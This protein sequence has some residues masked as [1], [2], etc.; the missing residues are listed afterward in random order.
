ML[1]KLHHAAARLPW[2]QLGGTQLV[3]RQPQ[4]RTA[5]TA[6]RPQRRYLELHTALHWGPRRPLDH[7]N[8]S[9]ERLLVA[10]MRVTMAED[11]SPHR[12]V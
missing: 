9:S 6:G 3:P 1:F 2:Q 8:S 12:L 5:P 4:S 11:P 7:S 10:T